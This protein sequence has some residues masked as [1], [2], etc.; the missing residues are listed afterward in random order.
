M[1]QEQLEVAV[2]QHLIHNKDAQEKLKRKKTGLRIKCFE[3]LPHNM[4]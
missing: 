2:L 4:S 3:N 1:E